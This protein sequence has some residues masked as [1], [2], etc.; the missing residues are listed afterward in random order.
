MATTMPDPCR[1][2]PVRDLDSIRPTAAKAGLASDHVGLPVGIVIADAVV[3]H[4]GS[5]K[6]ASISLGTNGQPLDPSLMMREFKKGNL[7]RLDRDEEAKAFVSNALREAY[8]DADPK[9][10][11]RRLIRDLRHVADELAEVL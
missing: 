9:A 11:A 5:V 10:R 4:Y 7:S 8:G 2:D 6:A 3:R 1:S